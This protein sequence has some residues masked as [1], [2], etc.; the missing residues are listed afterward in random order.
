MDGGRVD[1]EGRVALLESALGDVSARLAAL[2]RSAAPAEGAA[3]SPVIAST[4]AAARVAAAAA[5]AAAALSDAAEAADEGAPVANALTL[6]GRSF[7]VLGGAFLLRAITEGGRLPV[8]V[9]ALLGLAY[10]LFWIGA[11]WRTG[12][13]GAR[14]SANVHGVTAALIAF[15]LVGEAATRLAAFSPFVAAVALAVTSA[16]FCASGLL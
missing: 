7:L 6:A 15:P 14:T 16:A 4:A 1:L 3:P 5:P 10:A 13:R 12:S 9:G 8:F 11:A 2:E